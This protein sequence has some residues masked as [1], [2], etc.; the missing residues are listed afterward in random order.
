MS[1]ASKAAQDCLNLANKLKPLFRLAESLEHI[2]SLDNAAKEAESAKNRACED[3]DSALAHLEKANA[4]LKDVELKKQARQAEINLELEELSKRMRAEAE[5]KIKNVSHQ[6]SVAQSNLSNVQVE[7]DR[8]KA[9]CDGIDQKIAEKNETL[10]SLQDD[11]EK[12]KK[13]IQSL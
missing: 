11:I 12:T 10:R 6:L 4:E 3:R 5:E 1:E 7:I 8:K 2:G 9:E 13:R